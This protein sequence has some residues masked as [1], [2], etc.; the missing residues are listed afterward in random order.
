MTGS[1]AST[2]ASPSAVMQSGFS[3]SAGFPASMTCT[4]RSACRWFGTAIVD[5]VHLGQHP[6]ERREAAQV[7]RRRPRGD[8][9]HNRGAV[10]LEMPEMILS[11]LSESDEADPQRRQSA[12][13]SNPPGV[14]VF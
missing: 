13:W 10:R 5:R 8:D 14:R 12:H 3:T 11:D 6:L 9:A 1:V 4:Q 2:A 7:R